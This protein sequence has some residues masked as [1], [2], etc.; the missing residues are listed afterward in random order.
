MTPAER[1]LAAA[2]LLDKRA[3]EATK[4]QWRYELLDAR[5][6]GD[7]PAHWVRF[8][9]LDDDGLGETTG[10]VAEC[11]WGERDG[12]Y[13][14]TMHPEVGKALAAWLRLEAGKP[15]ILDPVQWAAFADDTLTEPTRQI[16]SGDQEALTLADLLLAGAS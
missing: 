5:W 4:G 2:D 8:D 10:T 11:P 15:M 1:L 6:A 16:W 12:R 9:L 3:G 7:R 13:I 14:A